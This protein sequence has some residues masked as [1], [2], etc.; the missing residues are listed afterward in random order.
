MAMA[1]IGNYFAMYSC[2]NCLDHHCISGSVVQTQPTGCL[3]DR[4]AKW[5]LVAPAPEANHG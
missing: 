4:K 3:Y 5:V 2:N 1:R